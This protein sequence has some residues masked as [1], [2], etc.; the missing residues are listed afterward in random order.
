MKLPKLN[1]IHPGMQFYILS[2][3]GKTEFDLEAGQYTIGSSEDNAIQVGH[4]TVSSHHAVMDISD[5]GQVLIKSLVP[6]GMTDSDGDDQEMITLFPGDFC[7]IGQVTVGRES[8]VATPPN[9][10]IVSAPEKR[11]PQQVVSKAESKNWTD[12][13]HYPFREDALI[14]M[15]ILLVLDNV[16][17]FVPRFLFLAAAFMGILLMILF[18]IT[19]LGTVKEIIR[20]TLEAEDNLKIPLADSFDL[21]GSKD[22]LLKYFLLGLVW[23]GSTSF[24]AGREEVPLALKFVVMSI[25]IIMFPMAV[26]LV[27][28]NDNLAAGFYI[29]AIIRSILRAPLA[30]TGIVALAAISIGLE[31]LLDLL[32]PAFRE[33]KILEI[34]LSII[35]SFLSIYTTMMIARALGLYAHKHMR[36]T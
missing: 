25:P 30:Y 10:P 26:L 24:I 12:I 23:I 7:S 22:L 31:F 1:D 36:S 6:S 32:S 35:G 11:L 21:E 3:S 17:L 18:A 9:H 8:L 15:I 34:M 5:G 14:M 13:F 16:L 27:V 29:P 2:T 20:S 19:I 33:N 4:E 28:L